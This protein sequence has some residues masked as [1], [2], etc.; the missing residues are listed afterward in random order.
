MKILLTADWH[1][2]GDRPRCRMDEDWIESQAQDIRAV[3]NTA[4][5]EHCDEVWILGDLFHQP[6]CSTEAVNMLLRELGQIRND[7]GIRILPGNHDLPYH[8]YGN[9]EQSSLGIVLKSY[10]ELTSQVVGLDL[11]VYARP[12]GHDDP[13]EA[14]IMKSTI[15]CTHQLVYPN[16]EA[17]PL[18]DLPE[19]TAQDLLDKAPGVPLIITGDYHH[20]YIYTAPDGRRVVTPGCLNT[21]AA[22]LA[23]YQPRVYVLDTTSMAVSEHLLPANGEVAVDYL[24]AERER[25]ERMDRCLEVATSAASVSLSFTDNLREAAARPETTPG[26]RGII[27]EVLDHLN[28]DRR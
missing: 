12:F 2:R 6:R 25:D 18:P 20:G 19:P 15:Y 14:S 7:C 13:A 27:N 22:D 26:V 17:K 8:D 24:V 1:I 16:K 4:L 10:P 28:K 21:Q 9:L 3:H 5:Q 11:D 23:D